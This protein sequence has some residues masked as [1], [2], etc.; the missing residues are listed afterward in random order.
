MAYGVINE[1]GKIIIQTVSF[2][3]KQKTRVEIKQKLT[4]KQAR[5]FARDIYTYCRIAEK[6]A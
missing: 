2:D 5:A 4:I 3:E 1:N 6:E